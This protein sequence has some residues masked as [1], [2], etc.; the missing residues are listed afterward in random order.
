MKK[1]NRE[2]KPEERFAGVQ[3]DVEPYL[4]KGWSTEQASI[5][6]QWME[7]ARVWVE[8]AERDQLTIGAAVPFWLDG[9]EHEEL[10]EGND[11]RRWMVDKFDYVAIMAYRDSAEAIYNVSRTTLEEADKQK[12]QVW[13]GVELGQSTEGPG[14]SFHEQ[15]LSSVHQEINKLIPL[16]NRHSSFEGVAVHNYEAWRTKQETKVAHKEEEA[17]SDGQSK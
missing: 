10:G 11:L 15:S 6:E 8:N 1:Y 9:V 13:V 14:V 16:V 2:S 3:L 12:K 7:S 5:V 17:S 4:L